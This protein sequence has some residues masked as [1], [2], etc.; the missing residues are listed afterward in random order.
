MK[1]ENIGLSE[2]IAQLQANGE[3]WFSRQVAM[4]TLDMSADTFKVS[5]NRLIKKDRI[6]RIRSD[7]Y[8]IVPFEY[9]HAGYLPPN[10]FIDAYM[11]SIGLDYYVGLL[12]AAALHV[13]AHQQPM[14]FQ[15]MLHER[16]QPIRAGR[17][18]E[19]LDFVQ[20]HA[21]PIGETVNAIRGCLLF[22]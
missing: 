13:A 2:Y 10:W 20:T 16:L 12:S 3:Y 15:V 17:Y 14:I 7:F 11:K 22:R 6:H 1:G 8:I 19:D 9:K 4:K 18:S 5:A 21:I